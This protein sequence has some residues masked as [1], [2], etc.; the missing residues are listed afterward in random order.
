MCYTHLCLWNII[1]AP[2][3]LRAVLCVDLLC[4]QLFCDTYIMRMARDCCIKLGEHHMVHFYNNC[5]AR[6]EE[7]FAAETKIAVSM[8]G[9]RHLVINNSCCV[10]LTK[11]LP[12]PNYFS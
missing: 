3:L 12:K 1:S 7:I 10:F 9:T 6:A 4:V 11:Y 2:R 5:S 8:A